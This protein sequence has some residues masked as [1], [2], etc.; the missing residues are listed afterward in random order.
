VRIFLW[1][2]SLAA[3]LDGL[4]I[5]VG[6]ESALHQ[7]LAYIA[8]LAAAV[9]LSGAGIVEAIYRTSSDQV[10]TSEKIIKSGSSS[11]PVDL[12][13]E[14]AEKVQQEIALG[15]IQTALWDQAK[16]VAH[17]SDKSAIEKEYILLRTNVLR[18]NR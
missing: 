15:S 18:G 4:V 13:S 14:L 9:L 7:I 17:T 6:A 16:A 5:L 3:V 11:E 12:E 1:L 8:F 2:L 10:K